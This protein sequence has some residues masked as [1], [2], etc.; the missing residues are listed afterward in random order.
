MVCFKNSV[1]KS[2]CAALMLAATTEAMMPIKI[3]G[4]RFIKPSY[5]KTDEG[6]V[7]FIKGVDYQPGG[8]SAY[9]QDGKTDVLSDANVCL[10]DAFALQQ[11]GANTI[12]IYTIN[13]SINHD[14]CMSIFD[15]AGIYVLV[16]VNSPFY[17]ESLNRDDPDTSYNYW[18]IQRVFQVIDAFKGYSNL[19]GFISGN[20]VINDESSAKTV[21][22]YLRAVQRDMKQYISSNANRTIPVGYSAADVV[23]MRAATWEY[24]NCNIDGEDD[25]DSKA[26]FFGLNSYEWCSGTSD[27]KSAG[28]SDV[29]ST[30]QDAT[31]PVFFTE[32]GCNKNTPR[33]FDEVSEGVFGGL[34]NTLSG[35]LIYE[36]SEESSDY[37]LVDISS[38]DLEM[39]DDF[40]NLKSQYANS[41]IPVIS[42]DE[43]EEPDV[44]KCTAKNIT[45]LYSKFDADF[46]LPSQPG[47]IPN[48]IKYGVNNTNIG[49][50]VSLTDRAT[51]YS[52]S[53]SDDDEYSNVSIS[54]DYHYTISN[55]DTS[56]TAGS[57]SG[58]AAAT[59]TSSSSSKG[60]AVAVG[61]P[62]C[63]GALFAAVGFGALALL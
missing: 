43:V 58:S 61:S 62:S 19:L 49:K 56:A 25:D 45:S 52:I 54:I 30:F 44:F 48:L 13:P 39:E 50:M 33:T 38:G 32:Y 18:Y 4:S 8:S 20:E 5:N 51:N 2:I 47:G 41:S 22:P 15:A 17:N 37:G 7:F 46:D 21:P 6:E 26:D 3:V 12:R 29:N 40:A 11:L 42:L 24:F 16:D 27:W 35:G 63:F 10:R 14:K 28:Y 55:L 23:S 57:S 9:T 1:F 60:D 31:I 34:V 53:N 59:K 36:Y